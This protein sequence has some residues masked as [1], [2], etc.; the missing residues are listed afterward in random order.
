MSK[1]QKEYFEEYA[2]I[3]GIEHYLLHYP[4]Q[5]G[6]PVLLYIHGGPGSFEHCFAH[7]LNKAWGDLFTQIHWDQRGAGRTFMKNRRDGDPKSIKQMMSDLHGIINHLKKHYHTDKIVLLGHSWGSLLGSLYAIHCPQNVSAYIGT[8]QA[9]NMM[10]NERIGYMQAMESAKN[11]GNKKH[12]EQLESL[13]EYPPDD[14]RK[15]LKLIRKVQK[16]KETYAPGSGMK[17][18]IKIGFASPH[19][20][21]HDLIGLLLMS[22]TNYYLILK[23]LKFDIYK[24]GSHY[25]VPV[26]YILGEQDT[27]TPTVLAKEY[28]KT[29]EAPYKS[30][31][32]IPNTG[33][34]PMYEQPEAFADALKEVR[35]NLDQTEC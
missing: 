1:V 7:E 13:G 23:L 9:I 34:N 4:K 27:I 3:N 35:T 19:F 6:T 15:L 18:L 10:E 22:K 21:P 29:I 2:A 31:T 16:V 11:A 5:P 33:H 17:E 30:L 14:A 8:G 26:Y 24:Y 12:I 20:K 25:K 28:F 32:V